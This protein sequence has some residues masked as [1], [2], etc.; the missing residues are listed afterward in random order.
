LSLRQP[1]GPGSLKALKKLIFSF[2]SVAG[3]PAQLW[4]SSR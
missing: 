3:G 2:T 4:T 1:P